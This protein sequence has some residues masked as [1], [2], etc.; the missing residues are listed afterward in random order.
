V[1][2]SQFTS[3]PSNNCSFGI[4]RYWAV[5]DACHHTA[6][7]TQVVV[8]ADTTPPAFTCP[9]DVTTNTDPG[10]CTFTYNSG[11]V[12]FEAATI[13]ASDNCGGNVF[14]ANN[15]PVPPVFP[16]GTNFVIWT[17]TDMCGNSTTCMEKVVVLDS[18]APRISCPSDI[19]TNAN[20]PDGAIVTFVP[21]ATDNCDGNVPV[22]CTPA[23]G[24]T[25]GIGTTLVSCV[26]IDS[27]SN[28]ASCS[29]QVTVAMDPNS[30]QIL[31][32]TPQGNDIL[33]TWVMPQGVTGIVQSTAG[34]GSGG[35][36]NG[37]GDVSAPIFV[38]G[39]G[40]ITTNYLDAGVATNFPARYYRV[41]L[42]P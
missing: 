41:R 29:F 19:V 24:S 12:V 40:S 18:Q 2:F 15:A 42:V 32:V 22:I 16:K 5:T 35:Y 26:A 11:T 14:V 28:Q 34:D 37:F 25:F 21:S 8:V 38:T 4:V 20:N 33:L 13:T 6:I 10:V 30:F 1:V 17:A 39:T 23:S 7:A 9:P 31:S 36:S 27:S 3:G